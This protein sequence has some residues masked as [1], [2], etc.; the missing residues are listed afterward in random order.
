MG[1]LAG[2]GHRRLLVVT[3]ADI[4]RLKLIAP[5]LAA[6]DAARAP[7]VLFDAVTADA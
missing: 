1:D 3:D 4:V 5:F 6:L 2:F 7:H